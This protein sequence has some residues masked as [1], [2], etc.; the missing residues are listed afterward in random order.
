MLTLAITTSA[1]TTTTMKT[2]AMKTLIT[3]TV[4]TLSDFCGNLF[5]FVPLVSGNDSVGEGFDC[6]LETR[7]LDVG[8][9]A[10]VKGRRDVCPEK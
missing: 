7:R 8:S 10:A 6:H 4:I 3:L 5:S 2:L 1:M 9:V